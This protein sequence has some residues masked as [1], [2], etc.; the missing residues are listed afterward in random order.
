MANLGLMLLD[1]RGVDAPDIPGAVT[2]IRRA[3][4]RNYSPAQVSLGSLYADG[5]GV[6]ADAAEAAR[7]YRRAAEA[8][9]PSG[10]NALAWMLEEGN[11]VDKDEDEAERLY[12]LAAEQGFPDAMNNLAW[13]LY[14]R[15]RALDEARALATRAFEA[16]PDNPAYADTLAA[17]LIRQGFPAES[18]VLVDFA[19]AQEPDN[20]DYHE[21]R[22]DALWGVERRD[23][24]RAAWRRALEFT[25]SAAQRRRLE[26]KIARP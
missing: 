3:A 13:F 15:Q 19:V 14:A 5:R 12:R 26:A 7:W 16:Q 24:A 9:D 6:A 1:G 4:E 2:W 20:P 23:D 18:M 17:I 10:Q 22:G 25:Q 11:G 21:R 8:G